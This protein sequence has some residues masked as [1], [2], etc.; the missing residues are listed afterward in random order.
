MQVLFVV[1][2]N[3]RICVWCYACFTKVYQHLKILSCCKRFFCSLPFYLCFTIRHNFNY[4]VIL[5]S[6]ILFNHWQYINILTCVTIHSRY[7]F[8]VSFYSRIIMELFFLIFH[9]PFIHLIGYHYKSCVMNI[10]TNC[11]KFFCCVAKFRNT[12]PHLTHTIFI[13]SKDLYS[14]HKR[15]YDYEVP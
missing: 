5:R 6:F 4:N 2:H 12:W 3:Y 1:V 7:C 13:L 15:F 8:S 11:N 10:Y 14:A 9:S